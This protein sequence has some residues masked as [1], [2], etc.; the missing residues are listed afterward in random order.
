[1]SQKMQL[2]VLQFVFHAEACAP[3]GRGATGSHFSGTPAGC[4]SSEEDQ[5]EETCHPVISALTS[6]QDAESQEESGGNCAFVHKQTG[7][8]FYNRF[9]SQ[10]NST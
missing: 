6:E 8:K 2:L 5:Q 3:C 9:L 10:P 1:M 7:A 4:H